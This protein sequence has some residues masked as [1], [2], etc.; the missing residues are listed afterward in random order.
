MEVTRESARLRWGLLLLC[1]MVVAGLALWHSQLTSKYV[2]LLDQV[3]PVGA[4]AEIG[5]PLQRPIPG[6][7]ADAQ[8]WVRH[9]LDGQ[10][11]DR[12][13]LRHTEMDNAPKGRELHWNSAFAHL[14]SAA[15]R[16]E[17]QRTGQPLRRA[18]ENALAWFNLP[19]LLGC[20]IL[21][22]AWSCIRAGAGAGVLVAFAMIGHP[23]FY[24]GFVPNYADHHGLLV[25]AAL[26]VV[27][28]VAFMGAGW[29]NPSPEPAGVVPASPS[30]ARRAAIISGFCGAFGMWISAA[31][32][33]PVIALT[34]I[35]GLVTVVIF[36]R[37]AQRDG[38]IF[39]PALWRLWARVGATASVV[40]YCL[41]YAPKNLGLRLEVNHPF[42][43]LAWWGGGEIIALLAAWYLKPQ[44][45]P[46][47]RQWL[48]PAL[49]IALVPCTILVA[50]QAAFLLR[51][52]FVGELRHTVVEGMSFRA[53]TKFFG[54]GYAL[55]HLINFV[56]I[57]AGIWL[58]FARPR[59]R[60]VIG[61]AT[62]I[63]IALVA[64]ACWEIRWW[65]TASASVIVLLLVCVAAFA[66]SRHPKGAWILVLG[67]SL[68]LLPSGI[69]RRARSIESNLQRNS[70]EQVDLLQSL[71]RDIARALR[72]A[73]PTGEIVLL[74]SPDASNGIGYYG[75]FKTIGTLYWENVEGLKAAAAIYGAEND[76]VALDLI[77]QRGI[78]HL[79]YVSK[80]NFIAEFFRLAQPHRPPT[81]LEQTFAHRVFIQQKLPRWGRLI[82]YRPPS[83]MAMPDLN[84]M[85]LQVVPN[86][87]DL[88]ARW[89]LAKAQLELGNAAAAD[90]LFQQVISQAQPQERP[91]LLH[92]AGDIAY[93]AGADAHAVQ[94]YRAALGFGFNPRSAGEAA[95][96]LATSS[97][98]RVRNGPEALALLEPALRTPS[99][100]P[101]ILNAVAA[102]LAECG[103][104]GEAVDAAT[105]CLAILQKAGDRNAAAI[106][107]SRLNSYRANRPWR[108]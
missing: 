65:L 43:A 48:P 49:G 21:F 56:V 96:I 54:F 92:T 10:D 101:I 91:R 99:D 31:S 34:G 95:W 30:H 18:T 104:F 24:D 37:R 106:V 94:Y 79:A 83:T 103:R 35:A 73:S 84:V 88:E 75:L 50:G 107:E 74:A 19:L 53:A 87:S 44:V 64:L 40:F 7:F 105:R 46:S 63:A 26:G 11:S 67:I 5:T 20:V 22:S 15:G 78:T 42:H 41:E 90:S 93:Q 27:L 77:R 59:G 80:G 6:S 8:A 3:R 66:S 57:G 55:L 38:L 25:A 1:W 9:A 89:H 100:D 58:L 12:W 45:R 85:L 108:R 70:A 61:F 60:I 4:G 72:A 51:D 33:I 36:G 102:A 17:A 52:P 71:Y 28:G 76:E 86:Q 82:G 81:D 29:R 47:V 39:E 62:S 32:V 2:S 68:L 98:A 16:I 97:D 13:Q 69:F 14:I 23:S